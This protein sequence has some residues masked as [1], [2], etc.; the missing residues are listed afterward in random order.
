LLKNL[1]TETEALADLTQDG[2]TER[3][4]AL[5]TESF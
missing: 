2:K 3:Q 1:A 5:S 4:D